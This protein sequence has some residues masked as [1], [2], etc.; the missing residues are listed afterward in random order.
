VRWTQFTAQINTEILGWA[1]LAAI[2]T[3]GTTLYVT[4]PVLVEDTTRMRVEPRPGRPL[5]VKEQETLRHL[6]ADARKRMP[7]SERLLHKPKPWPRHR[8]HH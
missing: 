8:A 2:D 1:V 5:T 7:M 6:M 4:A 3:S